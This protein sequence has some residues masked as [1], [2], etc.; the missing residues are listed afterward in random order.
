MYTCMYLY[1][2]DEVG[3]EVGNVSLES[4]L[5]VTPA[6]VHDGEFS[7]LS[8]RT[9]PQSQTHSSILHTK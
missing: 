6:E 5:L 1:L 9:W 4:L 3:L 8:P 2:S 7:S